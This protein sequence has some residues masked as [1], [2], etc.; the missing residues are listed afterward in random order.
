MHAGAQGGR[1]MEEGG[2]GGGRCVM[3]APFHPRGRGQGSNVCRDVLISFQ[4]DGPTRWRIVLCMPVLF[5]KLYD[6]WMP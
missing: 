6:D 5:V 3:E 2:G 1:E 4:T